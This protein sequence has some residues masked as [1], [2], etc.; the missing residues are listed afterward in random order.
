MLPFNQKY[1]C[2]DSETCGLN[3]VSVKPWQ[4]AWILATGKEIT[5]RFNRFLF[6]PDLEISEGAARVTGFDI[7]YY[8]STGKRNQTYRVRGKVVNTLNPAVVWEEFS[9]YLYDSER[10]VIGQNVIGYDQ[11]VAA[12]LQ[13]YLGEKPDYSYLPRLYDT[14]VLGKAYKEGLEKPTSGDFL[15]WEYKIKHDKTLKA[16]SSQLYQLKNLGIP[17]DESKLHDGLF[18]VECTFKIFLELKKRMNF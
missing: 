14:Q 4:I 16:K 9:K 8:E 7:D 15:A 2:W 6:W 13:R 12:S 10:I 17:F 18:D 11:F 5:N 1:I 3:L